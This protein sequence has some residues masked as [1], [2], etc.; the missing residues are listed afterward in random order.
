MEK[1]I[2]FWGSIQN[3]KLGGKYNKQKFKS[4]IRLAVTKT[5]IFEQV[6]T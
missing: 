2:R 4:E 1:F 6:V 5:D 3:F